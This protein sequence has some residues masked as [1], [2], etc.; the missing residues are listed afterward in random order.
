M[1]RGMHTGILPPPN[2]SPPPPQMIFKFNKT[3]EGRSV[4]TMHLIK[5]RNF[6][7]G[8]F[9][10]FQ[11]LCS[12][13]NPS[14]GSGSLSLPQLPAFYAITK[15]SKSLVTGYSKFV[16]SPPVQMLCGRASNF[17]YLVSLVKCFPLHF[18]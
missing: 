12:L 16:C 1:Q 5:I 17:S 4:T 10:S 8:S 7:H 14:V 6:T 13:C 11:S 18:S 9:W 2:L 3:R 15:A